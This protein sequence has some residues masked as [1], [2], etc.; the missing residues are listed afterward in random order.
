MILKRSLYHIICLEIV[1][2]WCKKTQYLY[3]LSLLAENG[4]NQTSFTRLYKT[5]CQLFVY[6][7]TQSLNKYRYCTTLTIVLLLSSYFTKKHDQCK[8]VWTTSDP[9]LLDRNRVIFSYRSTDSVQIYSCGRYS[10]A[11]GHLNGASIVYVWLIRPH[12]LSRMNS[13]SI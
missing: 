4:K 7:V 9:L 6:F 12:A 2:Q 8:T 5:S 11:E 1:I 13:L 10:A 3:L